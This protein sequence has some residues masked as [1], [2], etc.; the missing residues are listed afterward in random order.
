MEFY[1]LFR[2]RKPCGEAPTVFREVSCLLLAGTVDH[3]NGGLSAVFSQ[4][5]RVPAEVHVNVQHEVVLV[6]VSDAV[7]SKHGAL[8][9]DNVGGGRGALAGLKRPL[10][11]HRVA[12]L[13]AGQHH[14]NGGEVRATVGF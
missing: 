8:V 9:D 13:V 3:E 7:L 1:G 5:G 11:A 12:S 4:I 10:D 6:R 2:N 14:F